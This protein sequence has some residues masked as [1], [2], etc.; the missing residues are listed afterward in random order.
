MQ[1]IPTVPENSPFSPGQRAWI[2][3][4][5]AGLFS[6]GSAASISSAPD[7]ETPLLILF[8]S[9]TGT[10]E[11]LARKTAALARSKGFQPTVSCTDQF[12][13]LPLQDTQN[14]L[15]LTSTY[16]DGEP[17]D[18][19]AGFWSFLSRPDAPRFEGLRY[20]VLAL[21][22]RNYPEFCKFGIACDLRLAELGAQRSHPRAECDVDYEQTSKQWMAAA[23]DS[24]RLAEPLPSVPAAEPPKAQV[25]QG[26]SRAQPFPATVLQNRLLNTPGSQREVRHYEILLEGS[27]LEYE[28]GDALGVFP[29]NCHD[30]VSDLLGLLG[31][32]GE[33]PTPG[34]ESVPLRLSLLRT[35]DLVKPTA[36][37]LTLLAERAPG[38]ALPELLAPEHNSRLRDYLS[39]RDLRDL[40][41]LSETRWSAE[42]LIP[43]LK[44]LQPRLYSISSS[45]KAHPGQVHLT[46]AAVRYE[47]HGRPRKGVCSTFLADRLSPDTPVP[48]F[49]QTSHGFRVPADPS[50][51]MIMVGPGTGIAP[52]RAFLEE[53][54]AVGASGRNWLFFG[55]QH[56]A[57]DFLYEAQIADWKSRGH[58]ERLSLAFSR[59]QAEKVY[60]QDRML[61][62]G[63]ELWA[64]L[65]EGAHFYVCGDAS[66]MAR[67][68]DTALQKVIQIH[69]S[70]S[71]EEA[72]EF[73]QELRNQKR[74]QRDVY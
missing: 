61:E 36:E 53:R 62:E 71:A 29:S 67:D 39:G 69:G 73:L 35:F 13:K 54:E 72:A 19:A 59:D 48:V 56:R 70:R 24:L 50:A 28:V 16:G 37:L 60:V 42:T 25:S 31:C 32:D 45:P 4:Y 46:V 49:V 33:E 7:P 6:T 47:A 22:D 66:R 41:L 3:G 64:W 57:Q 9:Q 63:A 15:L 51:P 38:S 44:K 10:A 26:F 8:G 11:A 5:L 30:L 14:L 34:Q 20:S 23:L 17:P 58:L 27:G 52:F 65:Q 74:Y 43:V 55:A 40:L 1:Q 21:G 18:N 12:Q 2:N 68:V